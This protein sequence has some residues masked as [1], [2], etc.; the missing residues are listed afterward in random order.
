[1]VFERSWCDHVGFAPPTVVMICRSA[2]NPIAR[3]FTA[4][5]PNRVWLADVTYSPTAEGWLYLAAVMDLFSPEIVGQGMRDHM[6][7][8]LASAALTMGHPAAAAVGRIDPPFRSR[9][10][11][12]LTRL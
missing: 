2:P 12:C 8:E 1:M 11:I 7:A 5:A 3:D 4:A 6:Q 10:A 9:R